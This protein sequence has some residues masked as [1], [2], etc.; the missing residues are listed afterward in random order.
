MKPP[1]NILRYA[2]RYTA[3]AAAM[4]AT[5]AAPFLLRPGDATVPSDA[6]ESVVIVTPHSETIRHE[7]SR[8][9]VK[10]MQARGRSVKVEWRTPGAG[11][12]QLERIVDSAF[13]DR[14]KEYWKRTLKRP[15]RDV[16][17]GEAFAN[18]RLKIP[19]DPAGDT[20]RE[21]ARR[22]FLES[23]V[24]IGIDLF[25]GGGDYPFKKFATKGYLVDSGILQRRAEWFTDAVIPARVSGETYYDPGGRWIGNCLSSFGIC[26]NTDSLRR[27]GV[28]TAP[29]Q[30]SDL[31]DP[32]L[33]RQVALADPT[34]SGSVTKA[35]EMLL[36]QEIRV[37]VE[38]VKD[39]SDPNRT[40]E[41]IRDDAIRTGWR[42]GLNLIQRICANAR[43]FTDSAT[44]IPFDVAQGNSAAGMCIDFYGRTYNERLRK[45]RT[46]R[47]RVEYLTPV[48]GSSTGVDPFALFRGA[49]NRELALEFM[50][51]VLSVEGQKIWG[52]R[53]GTEGGPER[54]ALRRMPIRRDL[55]TAEHRSNSADPEVL[56]YDTADQFEYRPEWTG[57]AFSA[58]RF[59]IR[60]M[61]I[62]CHDEMRAAWRE[63]IRSGFPE[64]ASAKFFDVKL[65]DYDAIATIK[66]RLGDDDK[67]SEVDMAREIGHFFRSNY[68]KA[69]HSAIAGR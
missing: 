34:K 35:F 65:V 52:Y 41:Q 6:T 42:N 21:H 10:H 23:R 3:V 47:S 33:F 45:R 8:A 22:A 64:D 46:G 30:W 7:F 39:H 63:L 53:V 26:Y 5:L 4:L 18:R 44:K 19:D 40:A 29:V 56:P 25:F 11:T 54:S 15:W 13:R 60:V 61:C 50:E 31:G 1:D 66:R 68:R 48:G 24:G 57:H 27:L 38:A 37:A 20:L 43:Y 28:E 51:F 16:E 2:N 36:Q 58:L 49:P 69:I 12:A 17:V 32:R 67:M 59:I 14:F 9:F 62:E 55:Y